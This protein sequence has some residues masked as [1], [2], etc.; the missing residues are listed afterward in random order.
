MALCAP[1]PSLG[2]APLLLRGGVV[3]LLWNSGF[4]RPLG[5]GGKQ[6]WL[7]LEGAALRVPDFIR[8]AKPFPLSLPALPRGLLSL[9]VLSSLF[10][11]ISSSILPLPPQ[12]PQP[13]E[14]QLLTGVLSG[15]GEKLFPCFAPHSLL[16]WCRASG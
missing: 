12:F 13:G 7:P 15:Y 1:H 2:S 10:M 16:S 5:A 6:Q 14:E 3:V 11:E 4:P 9:G 8:E